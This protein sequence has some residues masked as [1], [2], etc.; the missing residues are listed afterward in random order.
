MAGHGW[1][2][3][4]GHGWPPAKNIKNACNTV[5][6]KNRAAC[7]WAKAHPGSSAQVFKNRLWGRRPYKGPKAPSDDTKQITGGTKLCI[8]LT[9]VLTLLCITWFRV[10]VLAASATSITMLVHDSWLR[11]LVLAASAS[12]IT[13]LL[14]D[15]WLRIEVLAASANSITMLTY[16]AS[17]LCSIMNISFGAP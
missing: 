9:I 4:V 2:W 3:P 5:L 15:K 13:V 11:V 7:A 8:Y 14:Y 16:E 6:Q 10:Q 12:S 17:R 1:P